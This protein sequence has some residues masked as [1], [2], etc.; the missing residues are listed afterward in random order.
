MKRSTTPRIGPANPFFPLEP[1]RA[2]PPREAAIVARLQN[3]ARTQAAAAYACTVA[4]IF[5]TDRVAAALVLPRVGP[6]MGGA[7]TRH[8]AAEELPTLRGDILAPLPDGCVGLLVECQ[9]SPTTWIWLTIGP[10]PLQ[11]NAGAA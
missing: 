9:A 1:S 8:D 3:D 2:L 7:L 6:P 4:R 11:T 5:G 10:S